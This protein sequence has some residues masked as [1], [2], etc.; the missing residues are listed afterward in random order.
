MQIREEKITLIYDI[1]G[2]K[3]ANFVHNITALKCHI[4]I[5]KGDRQVNGKSIL[6]LLSIAAKQ[7]EELYITVATD[8]DD[9]G[10]TINKI[11]SFLNME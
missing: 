7:R 10:T 9:G 3:A 1:D 5:R 8:F 6:G 11:I 4:W 2:R